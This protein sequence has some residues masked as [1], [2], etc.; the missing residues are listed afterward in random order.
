MKLNPPGLPEIKEKSGIWNLELEAVFEQLL[1]DFPLAHASAGMQKQLLS[2]GDVV[3]R[4][5]ASEP[6]GRFY[7]NFDR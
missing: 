4:S 6:E 1:T 7:T 5:Q 3:D 2:R